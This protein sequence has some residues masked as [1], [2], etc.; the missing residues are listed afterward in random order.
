MLGGNDAERA[1]RF[2][3]C[4][5]P[6]RIGARGIKATAWRT[7]YHGAHVARWSKLGR[8]A[9]RTIRSG[10]AWRSFGRDRCSVYSRLEVLRVS[11]PLAGFAVVG[12]RAGKW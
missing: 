3:R 11:C 7:P 10:R 9:K 5:Q 8:R 1:A 6:A 4:M 2:D 12:R